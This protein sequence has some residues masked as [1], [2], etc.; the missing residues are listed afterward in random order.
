MVL[1]DIPNSHIPNYLHATDNADLG[2]SCSPLVLHDSISHMCSTHYWY[3]RWTEAWYMDKRLFL[4]I[5]MCAWTFRLLLLA[6]TLQL[7]SPQNCPWHRGRHSTNFVFMNEQWH[8]QGAHW[9]L[10][11]GGL[12]GIEE[13]SSSSSS[14]AKAFPQTGYLR[15][16]ILLQTKGHFYCM[17]WELLTIE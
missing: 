14:V 8:A 1:T 4:L 2:H 5:E 15:Y 11:F 17:S 12:R 10:P 13:W 16:F 3:L 6:H 7:P 9:C